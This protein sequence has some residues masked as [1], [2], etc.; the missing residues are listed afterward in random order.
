MKKIQPLGSY[1]KIDKNG[2][3]QNPCILPIQQANFAK[4]TNSVIKE[5]KEKFG[6]NLKSIYIRGSVAKGFAI[7]S[8]SDLDLILIINNSLTE[9]E[10]NAK[11]QIS[12]KFEIDFPFIEGVELHCII[13]ENLTNSRS[14]FLLKT[15][16]ICIFGVDVAKEFNNFKID[17]NAYAH[18]FSFEKDSKK[19]N[20]EKIEHCNWI[21]KR[22]IRSGFELVM[23]EEQ[24][25][26]R[27]LYWCC[28][29]FEKYYKEEGRQMWNLL[30][31]I[32]EQKFDIT[33][34][35]IDKW[36]YFFSKQIEERKNKL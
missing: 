22:I 27:D 24:L 29:S 1:H 14:Q 5:I 2:F 7:P 20:T 26:T 15:Q 35:K 13:L 25:Y 3:I 11:S 18:L 4:A 28:L 23:K 17:E 34:Q 8:L 21:I 32:I 36:N 10:K 19:I 33:Q 30:E 12:D 9:E 6:N 31:S 16:C